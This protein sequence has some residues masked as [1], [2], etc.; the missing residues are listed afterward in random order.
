MPGSRLCLAARE[1]IRAGLERGDSIREIARLLDRSASTI[2]REIR[3]IERIGRSDVATVRAC[4]G[5]GQIAQEVPWDTRQ[6]VRY[7]DRLGD[8]GRRVSWPNRSR[9]DL[10]PVRQPLAAHPGDLVPRTGSRRV[11]AN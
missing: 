3:L 7:R 10:F 1:E 4:H 9:I 11:L 2:S 5:A 8:L 6:N